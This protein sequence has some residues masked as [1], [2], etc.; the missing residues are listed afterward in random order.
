MECERLR[1]ED[2]D[3][4][5]PAAV[6]L[7][8]LQGLD[9]RAGRLHRPQ[10]L[11][12]PLFDFAIHAV[13]DIVLGDS[14]PETAQRRRAPFALLRAL[15]CPCPRPC[16]H[17][18]GRQCGHRLG[19]VVHRPAERPHRV[20]RPGQRHHALRRDE[21]VGRLE[22]DRAAQRRGDPDRARGIR[23]ER[24]RHDAGSDG[25]GG[26]PAGPAGAERGIPRVLR[27]AVVRIVVGCAE[28]ELVGVG[29]A[30]EDGAGDA[31]HPDDRGVAPRNPVLEDAGAGG[32]AD[33]LRRDQ[34]LDAHGHA[35]ER[36]A[37]RAGGQLLRRDPGIR[38][39]PVGRDGDEGVELGLRALDAFERFLDEL[40]E[41][42][43]RH[44]QT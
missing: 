18:L 6:Q 15:P 2:R 44:A 21:P 41:G 22:A 9:H 32:G 16:H 28:R 31:Q 40:R 34:V 13:V 19:D 35:V 5:L 10:R 26:S 8:D 37:A 39:R 42:G 7:G 24:D 38:Q 23:A 29:L 36:A 43:C 11:A 12:H 27:R 30:D 17:P 25:R 33:A 4:H 20:Q 3:S 14:D 1:A